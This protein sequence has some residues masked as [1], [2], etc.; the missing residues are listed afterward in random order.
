MC[1]AFA[2]ALPSAWNTLL[3][4]PLAL[5]PSGLCSNV[6][7]VPSVCMPGADCRDYVNRL[8]PPGLAVESTLIE[9]GGLVFI[10]QFPPRVTVASPHS[11]SLYLRQV[12]FP[13]GLRVLAAHFIIPVVSLH[14]AQTL[15]LLILLQWPAPLRDHRCLS[16]PTPAPFPEICSRQLSTLHP[17]HTVQHVAGASYGVAFWLLAKSVLILSLS[18]LTGQVGIN[19]LTE[20]ILFTS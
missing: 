5:S 9:V 17:W 2:H 15:P 10:P 19:L 12:T 14:P 1:G 18:F 8:L 16:I 20:F 13:A 4:C 11:L 3:R 7:W 6:M